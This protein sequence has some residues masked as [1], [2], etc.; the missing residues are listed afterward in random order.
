MIKLN[1]LSVSLPKTD[2]A[3]IRHGIS[4]TQYTAAHDGIHQVKHRGGE[5]GSSA[6]GLSWSLHKQHS[7]AACVQNKELNNKGED[8]ADEKTRLFL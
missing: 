8:K 7:W 4:Q 6:S 2:D 1:V 5:W 3:S